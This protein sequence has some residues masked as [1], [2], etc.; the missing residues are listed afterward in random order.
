MSLREYVLTN[1]WLK[2]FSLVLAMLIWFSVRFYA[3][4]DIRVG[5]NPLSLFTR[6]EFIRV[7]VRLIP[8][9]ESAGNW[10]LVPDHVDVTVS[11]DKSILNNLTARDIL[12]FVSLDAGARAGVSSNEVHVYTPPG[13]DVTK[14]VPALVRIEQFR[15]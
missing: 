3:K 11:G 12:A 9:M 8:A 1:L 2:C 5:R 15:P 4:Q 7:P 13:M 6:L 14:V 10:K